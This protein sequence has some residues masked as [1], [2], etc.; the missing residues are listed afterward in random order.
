MKP[1][2]DQSSLS[3]RGVG[4]IMP[5]HVPLEH[6]LSQKVQELE[7]ELDEANQRERATAEVLRVISSSPANV[8]AVFDTIVQTA[9]SLCGS[10]FA[11]I[12]R[13]DS[14][15][16]HFVAGPNVGPNFI[17]LYRAKSPM[18]S[19]TSQVSGRVL[20][21]K[22]VVRLEDVLS[23]PDYDQRFPRAMG[24]RRML[25]VP[26]LRAGK[27]LGVVVVGWA[28]PGPVS[29]AQEELL[30]TFADQAVI[31]I[32]NARLFDEVQART[33][34]LTDALEQQTATS[35]VLSVIS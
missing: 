7:R 15:L 4:V 28:E 20:L 18:Q 26:I 22:S 23:D 10:L 9:V 30:K 25:G 1:C 24:S 11:N 21:T 13:F 14:E 16:L 34:E 2:Q 35:E 5:S 3:M 17:G 29:I 33:R 8:Q 19:N 12:F 32:E 6:D 31:A 27:P